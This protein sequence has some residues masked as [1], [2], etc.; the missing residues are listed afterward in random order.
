MK[1]Y[2]SLSAIQNDLHNGSVSCVALVEQYTARIE[3]QKHLHVFLGGAVNEN[4][5]F[6]SHAERAYIGY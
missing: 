6:S 2:T 3:A 4:G 5:N 1:D